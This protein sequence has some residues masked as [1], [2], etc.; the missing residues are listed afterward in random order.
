[1]IGNEPVG[2][3]PFGASTATAPFRAASAMNA[4]P[5]ALEPGK[6]ANR[7]PGST[8]RE[9]S[10]RPRI[11]MSAIRIFSKSRGGVW[12]SGPVSV[13]F[14]SSIRRNAAAIG[15]DVDLHLRL[16]GGRSFV[17]R[18]DAEQRPHR[19]DHARCGRR[20]DPAAGLVAGALL[21][22]V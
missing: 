11:S 9:S 19:G 6:A 10:V 13:R 1:M 16:H 4:A 2:F 18:R 22:A 15:V 7:K 3:V 14:M 21:V 17:D 8:A 20:R 12:R 5:S